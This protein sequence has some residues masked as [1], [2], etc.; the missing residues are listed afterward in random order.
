MGS[1]CES[2]IAARN[3]FVRQ[4]TPHFGGTS[5]EV[6]YSVRGYHTP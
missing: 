4:T 2:P 1:G 6:F 5:R 3:A